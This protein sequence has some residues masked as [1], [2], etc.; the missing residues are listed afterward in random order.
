MRQLYNLRR[1][2]LIA[3]FEKY[4]GDK[5][6]ILGENAG[7]H[8]VAKIQTN[9]SDET[10]IKKAAAAG[11]GLVSTREYYLQPKNRGEFIFGYGQ[12]EQLEIDRGIAKLAQII[13]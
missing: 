2:A 5:V 9:L 3:A 1:Q 7:I 6:T 8:L 10:I 12:L 11:I 13:N 4:F